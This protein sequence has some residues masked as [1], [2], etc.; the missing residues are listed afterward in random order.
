MTAIITDKFRQL[1]L[2]EQ[3]RR[4]DAGSDVYWLGIGRAEGWTDDANPPT[5]DVSYADEIEARH[6]LQ[7]VKKFDTAKV[8][9][10][11][12]RHN[13]VNGNTYVAYDDQ[14]PDLHTKAYYVFNPNNFNVYIC[15]KAGTGASTIEPTGVDD[16]GSNLEADRG[17]VEPTAGADGYIWKYLYTISAPQATSF[18]TTDF[19][20]VFKDENV[21]DNAKVTGANG[22]VGKIFNVVVTDGGAGYDSVPTVTIEGDGTGAT[23]TAVVTANV[24][25][26]INITDTGDNY[27]YARVVLSGGTPETEATAH[28]V[29]APVAYGREIS[30]INVTNG[31]TSYPG[32]SI[33]LNILGDGYEATATATVTAGVIQGPV[34]PTESG[35]GYTEARIEPAE[36]TTGTDAT[37]TV[38]LSDAVGGFGYDVVSDLNAYYLMFNVLLDGDEDPTSGFQGD[39]IVNNNYRQIMIFKNLLDTTATPLSFSGGGQGTGMAMSYLDV[40]S[41]GTWNLDDVITGGTSQAQGIVNYYDANT[42]RVYYTQTNATGFGTFNAAESITGAQGSTGTTDGAGGSGEFDKYSGALLYLENRVPVSRAIDQ[43]EDI[44]LVI[45][46]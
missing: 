15:L 37:F 2:R 36:S 14:D 7:A 39:F 30:A 34:T 28:A 41:G 22:T 38:E 5:P 33:D 31:G 18:L 16:G 42:T 8:A 4:L 20:P 24:V 46:F 23:A 6:S 21:Q 25:T 13:W 40:A 9:H 26:A 43:T 44:K 45:Q 11:A 12:P 10:C 19:I 29:V 3:K 17:K 27:T 32:A 1:N 35:W